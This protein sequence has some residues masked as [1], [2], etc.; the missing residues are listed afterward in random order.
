VVKNTLKR[1]VNKF[2]K[3]QPQDCKKLIREFY[4]VIQ[5]KLNEFEKLEPG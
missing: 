2:R 4:D 3:E 1:Y 5:A